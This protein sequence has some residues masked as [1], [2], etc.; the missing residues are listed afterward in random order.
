MSAQTETLH[1]VF[2]EVLDRGV[3]LEGPSGIGKSALALELINRGHKLIADDAPEFYCCSS[4]TVSGIC[5]APLQ[6]FIEV[7]GLG[8]LN[9]PAMFGADAVRK[10]SQLQLLISLVPAT[11]FALM[12]DERLKGSLQHRAILGI[13]IPV[14]KLPVTRE[15]N[16]AIMV[17]SAVRNHIL[18]AAGY[19]AAEDFISRQQF[20]LGGDR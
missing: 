9:I 5:P 6:D 7:F 11:Q 3:L 4:T 18:R 20:F 13:G 12:E 15:Y 8:V 19:N 2:I 1:G 14:V 10:S 17:E 16:M